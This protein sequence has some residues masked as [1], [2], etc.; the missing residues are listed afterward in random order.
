[1][2]QKLKQEIVELAD[3]LE[4]TA[5]KYLVKAFKK[6]LLKDGIEVNGLFDLLISGH[7]SSMI[8]CL[9]AVAEQDKNMQPILKSAIDAF[10]VEL[11]KFLETRGSMTCNKF[12]YEKINIH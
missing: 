9:Y 5:F 4:D 8:T 6:D 11:K 1:M 12:V 3:L 10:V 2:Q 7:I